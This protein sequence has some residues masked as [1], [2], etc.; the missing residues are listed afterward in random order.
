MP[1]PWIIST[2]SVSAYQRINEGG[3]DEPQHVR[4][5]SF[6]RSYLSGFVSYAALMPCQMVG[7]PAEIVT[8]SADIKDARRAG[9]IY[10][11]GITC[12]MPSIVADHGNP[13]PWAWN[14]G[15]MPHN[16]SVPESPI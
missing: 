7:T 2:P 11:L 15:T 10:R 14:I 13:Q 3:G 16:V 4:R 1:H 9:S 6:D 5:D 8:P 12:F